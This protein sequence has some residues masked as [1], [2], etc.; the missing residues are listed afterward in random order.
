[1]V[2]DTLFLSQEERQVKEALFLGG[3]EPL[4]NHRHILEQIR[5]YA[6]GEKEKPSLEVQEAMY[7]CWNGECQKSEKIE[8]QQ[9]EPEP[10]PEIDAQEE[11]VDLE[12]TKL[13]RKLKIQRP[14][15]TPE[16]MGLVE[17]VKKAHENT[18]AQASKP[19][20]DVE[21]GCTLSIVVGTTMSVVGGLTGLTQQKFCPIICNKAKV[22]M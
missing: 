4:A 9:A 1:M 22:R 11:V 8:F 19:K 15:C 5:E 3:H 12:H 14:Q 6:K 20:T 7:R 16:T 2:S 17:K 18:V 21:K 10:E 13:E